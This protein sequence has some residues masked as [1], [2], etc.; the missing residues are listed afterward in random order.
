MSQHDPTFPC[1]SKLCWLLET[2]FYKLSRH[3]LTPM[4]PPRQILPVL[5][6][7]SSINMWEWSFC[8]SG[9]TLK[10]A[11][12][13]SMDLLIRAPTTTPPRRDL[14]WRLFG[15]KLRS[16]HVASVIVGAHAFLLSSSPTAEEQ[17][18]E[19]DSSR[20]R[21]LQRPDRRGGFPGKTFR[22]FRASGSGHH[23]G[24][25]DWGPRAHK[26]HLLLRLAFLTLITFHLLPLFSSSG[27]FL[28]ILLGPHGKTKSY[29]EIGRAIATLMVDDV[30][31]RDPLA[32]ADCILLT[33]PLFEF[34]SSFPL[35]CSAMLP[36]EPGTAKTWLRALMSS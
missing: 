3:D 30:S 5:R 13:D 21:S 9:L 12:T 4:T 20:C 34:F 28:F 29:N 6:S 16:V 31:S 10:A 27:R 17:I 24:G 1:T 25:P 7:N 8:S 19:E 18:H 14:T 15:K 32:S 2:M 11:W 36:I 33:F 23:A 22:L 26:V 35:S